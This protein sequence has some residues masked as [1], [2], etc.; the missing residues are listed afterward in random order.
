MFLESR[1]TYGRGRCGD[2]GSWDDE[3]GRALQPLWLE[4]E[5]SAVFLGRGSKQASH[6]DMSNLPRQRCPPDWL[7]MST[8]R[9]RKRG[10]KP[11]HCKGIRMLAAIMA[12]SVGG[13]DSDHD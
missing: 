12:Q 3:K 13:L 8:A 10:P 11:G 9:C 2:Y 5:A 1:G 4:L 6:S 7:D